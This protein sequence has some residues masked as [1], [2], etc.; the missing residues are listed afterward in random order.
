MSEETRRF[1][2][3]T[4]VLERLCAPLCDAVTGRPGSVGVLR[5]LE[6]SN[7]F[8]IPLDTRREWYCYHHLFRELLRHEL[9]VDEPER[10]RTFTAGPAPGT[11]STTNP[12]EAIHHATA[13]GDIADTSE[14]ILRYW[15]DFRND[16]RLE[17]LLAWLDGLPPATVFG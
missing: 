10:A 17:T 8:L 14:L 12:S 16:A 6:R 7:V 13:A 9:A 15:I 5:E 3:E 2:L 4:S 1:L 11:A